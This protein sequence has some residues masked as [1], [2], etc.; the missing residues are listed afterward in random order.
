MS[1]SNERIVTVGARESALSRAQVEEVQSALAR[2]HPNIRFS[3]CW[4]RTLGDLDLLTS[5]RDMEKT[6]FFTQEIDRRQLAGEFQISVHSAKDLPDP[7]PYG[8]EIVALTVCLDPSDVLVLPQ[9][10]SID[11]LPLKGA[12]G[13]SSIRRESAVKRVRADL[14]CKEIRGSIISRLEQLDRGDYDGVVM[15]EAALLRLKLTHRSRVRLPTEAAPLQGQ[16][17]VVALRGDSAMHELFA[18]ID[19]RKEWAQLST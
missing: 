16:L 5:L 2:F 8:L 9:G 7:L 11:D 6:D 4:F 17:A 14:I 18:C 1:S 10:K 12:I 15:A 19:T 13:T 3:T